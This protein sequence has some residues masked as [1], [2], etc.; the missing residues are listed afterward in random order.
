VTTP[1]GGAEQP[2]VSA[3]TTGVPRAAD[4]R[5]AAGIY[6]TIVTASVLATAGDH[7]RPVPLAVA[8]FVTLLVYWLAEEYAEL[9]EHA[10]A[11]H[12]PT[13]GR[14]RA[15]LAAKW[16]MVSASYLPLLTLLGARL[17]GASPSTAAYVGLAVTVALLMIYGWA[18]GSAS[19]LSAAGRL[20][21]TAAAGTLGALMILLKV[22]IVHLH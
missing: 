3:E 4:R 21:L 22:A 19:G 13:W 17:L 2:V 8:V 7:L 14:T 5:R 11:G 9:G 10:T 16:P 20:L 15:D 18:A 6:G 12:L 1:A